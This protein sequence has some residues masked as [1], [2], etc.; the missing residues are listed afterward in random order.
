MNKDLQERIEKILEKH[1][2]VAGTEQGIL[3][4]IYP[5]IVAIVAKEL[6]ALLTP[7]DTEE[8]RGFVEYVVQDFDEKDNDHKMWKKFIEDKLD[9][10]NS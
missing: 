4:E 8:L 1:L 9:E 6:S 2:F 10:Y 3:K 7:K 5:D